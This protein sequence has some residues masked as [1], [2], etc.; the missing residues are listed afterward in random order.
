[1]DNGI[2]FNLSSK[3]YHALPAEIISNSYL[4]KLNK[5]P[6]AAKIET[7]GTESMLFGQAAHT[8]ILEGK[9]ALKN[10]FAICEPVDKRTKD[11][12]E[13]FKVF[14]EANQDKDIIMQE[15]YDIL[16]GMAIAVM[17][18]PFATQLLHE[19][20]SEST[21]IWTDEETGIQ[22]KCRPDRTPANNKG[23]LVDLKTIQD[24]NSFGKAVMGYGYARQAAFYTEGVKKITGENYDAFAFIVVEKEIPYRTEVYV[25][26]SDYM[27]WGYNE[28]HRLLRLEKECRDKNFWPHY[29]NAGA[30]DL[31]KPVYL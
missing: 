29:Q 24:I 5:C 26:G 28:N 8:L 14:K 15:D 25:L 6:A 19:G 31:F 27:E 2:Y 7:K 22:C 20:I 1:M 10:Q 13:A 4:S 9:E 30:E 17:S 11:G 23:V 21:T 16:V 12:R 18:H 3:E